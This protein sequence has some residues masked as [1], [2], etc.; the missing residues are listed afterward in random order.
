MNHRPHLH[1]TVLRLIAGW[2]GLL[3]Y[4]AVCSPLGMGVAAV[5]GALDPD[6]HEM[7]QPAAGGVRLILQHDDAGARH[8]HH[9]IAG[10]LTLFA[11]PARPAETDHVVQ[12]TCP[13]GFA[14]DARQ[15]STRL[16]SRE[17][18]QCNS[19]FMW[20][21]SGSG[22]VNLRCF[23]LPSPESPRDTGNDLLGIRSTVL[24]I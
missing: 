19:P 13:D 7:L 20:V 23:C 12:F 18:L 11:Q 24:L 3:I 22:P 15:T 4:V 2:G 16:I 8:Q 17:S 14:N 21:E 1:D 10:M 6:H 9:G 5:L